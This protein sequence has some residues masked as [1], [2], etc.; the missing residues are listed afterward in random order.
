MP[1]IIGL[2]METNKFR[3]ARKSWAYDLPAIAWRQARDHL[4]ES[5]FG[6]MGGK[7]DT[8]PMSVYSGLA[9]ISDAVM[10]MEHHPALIPG[11][12]VKG[13]VAEIIPA[14]RRGDVYEPYANGTDMLLL[15]PRHLT[16]SGHQITTW[17][18]GI[19]PAGFEPSLTFD[20]DFHA[21]FS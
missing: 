15:V 19:V 21:L 1:E 14:W 20:P 16:A 17:N 11:R 18:P 7:L 12:G 5:C 2:A 8:M 3:Y 6:P 9:K 4:V 13:W 10:R